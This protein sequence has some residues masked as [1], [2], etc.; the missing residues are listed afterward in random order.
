M[1]LQ[2]TI[3]QLVTEGVITL[4]TDGTIRMTPE[5]LRRMLTIDPEAAEARKMNTRKRDG[6]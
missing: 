3:D 4:D 2:S 1:T 5:T 6:R